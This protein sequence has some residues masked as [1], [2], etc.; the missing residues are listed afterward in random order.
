M[1]LTDRAV[2]YDVVCLQVGYSSPAESGIVEDLGLSLAEVNRV[3]TVTSLT[4]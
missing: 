2:G 3:D 1:E 4:Y